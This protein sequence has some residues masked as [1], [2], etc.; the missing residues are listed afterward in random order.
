MKKKTKTTR[1]HSDHTLMTGVLEHLGDDGFVIVG[2]TKYSGAEIASWLRERND[3]LQA[4]AVAR[5]EATRLKREDDALTARTDV[6]LALV[7]QTLL[8]MYFGHDAVLAD[9]G[10]S[11]R[12]PPRQLTAE[13]KKAKAD[14]IRATRKARGTI[15]P[16]EKAKIRGVAAPPRETPD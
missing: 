8:A 16:R 2:G 4:L 13:E 9:L 11:P 12:K 3:S 1:V 7:R 5:A 6:L 10:L 14:K 15:G